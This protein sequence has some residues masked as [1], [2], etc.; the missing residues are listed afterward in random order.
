MSTKFKL[1][2]LI[3]ETPGISFKELIYILSLSKGTISLQ[4]K[5][6]EKDGLIKKYLI[7]E[8]KNTFRLH[9]TVKGK[10][11]YLKKEL[12]RINNY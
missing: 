8:N 3:N 2:K 1:L 7:N 9:P 6:L 4:L 5:V 12:E 10:N 11:L